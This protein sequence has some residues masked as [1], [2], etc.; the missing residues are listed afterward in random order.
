[1]S[2]QLAILIDLLASASLALG[3]RYYAMRYRDVSF[4]SSALM[5]TLVIFPLSLLWPLHFGDVSFDIAP[6][7]WAAMIFAAAVNAILNLSLLASHA[8]ID[9]AQVGIISQLNV[10]VGIVVSIIFLDR[11]LSP[12]QSLGT[13]LV[14][15]A[16]CGVVLVK[17]SSRT[18]KATSSTWYAISYAFFT[19]IYTPLSGYILAKDGGITVSTFLT[20]VIGMQ[21]MF[22]T[23]FASPGYRKVLPLVRSGALKILVFLG[24]ARVISNFAYYYAVRVAD[25]P[26]LISSARAYKIVF[27]MAGS[28][29]I[30]RERDHLLVKVFGTIFAT[31]GLLLLAQN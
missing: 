19:G 4:Q 31:T 14:L 1:M 27:L 9:A 20:L 7:I 16:A 3:M 12:L 26:A 29:F 23:L 28:Y 22:I 10:V 24:L 8:D 2:W 11:G 30:M 25:N 15:A 21:A 18:L 17:F 5:Y 6:H 13:A